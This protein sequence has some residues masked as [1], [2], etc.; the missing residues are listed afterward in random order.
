VVYE[1]GD[2]PVGYDVLAEAESLSAVIEK[3]KA[4]TKEGKEMKTVRYVTYVEYEG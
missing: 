1:W 3:Y 2:A 4:T